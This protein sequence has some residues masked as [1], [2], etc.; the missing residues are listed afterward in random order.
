MPPSVTPRMPMF[1]P[2][3]PGLGNQMFY[4]QAPPMMPPQGGF[5]YQQQLVPGMRPGSAPVPNFFLPAMMAHQQ[6]QRSGGRRGPGPVQ[7]NQPPVPMMQQQMVPRGGRIYRYP[8]GRNMSD[9]PPMHGGVAGGLLPS[10]EMGGMPMREGGA[11]P[12]PMSL[13]ALA[14]ALANAAPDHQRTMLGESL[15]PLV[16]ALEHEN[17]AK[18]T[19]MLLE[20]DQTEVLHLLESPDALKSKVAEAMDVLRNVAQQQ[21]DTADQLASLS[22]GDNLGS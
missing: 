17:A 22:L 3:A 18:V 14:T 5:G 4:G 1:P 20:M 13:T 8:P 19:G 7:P 12:Q 11:V 2:G 10:Y 6:A 16:D 15:Y 21:A 9:V